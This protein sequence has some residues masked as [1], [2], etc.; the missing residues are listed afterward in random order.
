L[1]KKSQIES[2]KNIFKFKVS[3]LFYISIV[4]DIVSYVQVY[5]LFHL[6]TNILSFFKRSLLLNFKLH[7]F[8]YLYIKKLEDFFGGSWTQNEWS[9]SLTKVTWM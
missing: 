1:K 2:I 6:N 9:T 4:I 7:N 5:V 3:I 8:L